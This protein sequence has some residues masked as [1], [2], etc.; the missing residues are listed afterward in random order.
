MMKQTPKI[1]TKEI[2]YTYHA[3]SKKKVS[4]KVMVLIYEDQPD[5][6]NEETA[7]ALFAEYPHVK[8]IHELHEKWGGRWTR[9]ITIRAHKSN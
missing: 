6:L 9:A 1:Y 4:D 5:P 8:E 7:N 3:T 2:T